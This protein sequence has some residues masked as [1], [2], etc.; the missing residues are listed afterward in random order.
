MSYIQ[1][2]P[3]AQGGFFDTLSDIGSSVADAAKWGVNTYAQAQNAQANTAITPLPAY[4]TTPIAGGMSLS[5]MAPFL[6]AGGGALALFF[7]LKK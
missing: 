5:T 4:A 2:T 6:L 3:Q 1:G 7:V